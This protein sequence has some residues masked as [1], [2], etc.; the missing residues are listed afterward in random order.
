MPGYCVAGTIGHKVLSGMK[1]IEIDKK[2]VRNKMSIN[3]LFT[4]S[5]FCYRLQFVFLYSTCLSGVYMY[6]YMYVCVCLTVFIDLCP[7][8]VSQKFM[9]GTSH[10]LLLVESFTV[11]L[12]PP[13]SHSIPLSP[14][15]TPSPIA[16][17]SSLN[18]FFIVLVHMLMLKE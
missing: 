2:L 4:I 18:L 15:L 12:S 16:P 8:N 1:K 17:L 10:H 13:L 9:I 6:M 11:P 3:K 7:L 14:S 5:L